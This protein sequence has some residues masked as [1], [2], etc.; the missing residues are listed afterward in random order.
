MPSGHT[1]VWDDGVVGGSTK[2]AQGG[3]VP[4]AAEKTDPLPRLR[5]V[6]Y[7]RFDDIAQTVHERD[8]A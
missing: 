3:D 6:T 4:Q 5:S 2:H 7:R 8:G 1:P